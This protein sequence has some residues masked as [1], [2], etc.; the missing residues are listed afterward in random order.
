MKD[1]DIVVHAAAMKQIPASE[2]NPTEC[3]KTNIIGA[4]NVIECCLK[5][6][7]E[8]VIALSTD[9]AVSPIN[10]MVQQNLHQTSCLFAK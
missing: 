6:R 1:V 2:Y 5:N 9:K 10:Y 8:R 3:I 4:Q 7:I